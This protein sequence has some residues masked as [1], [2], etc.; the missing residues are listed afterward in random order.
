MNLVDKCWLPVSR[1][2]KVDLGKA[3]WAVRGRPYNVSVYL[4]IKDYFSMGKVD[5]WSFCY[6]AMLVNEAESGS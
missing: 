4:A 6:V 2:N 5:I 3:P 1:G